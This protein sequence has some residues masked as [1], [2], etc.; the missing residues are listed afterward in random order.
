[1]IFSHD[2]IR[3]P[4][5]AIAPAQ[6]FNDQ[7]SDPLKL[8]RPGSVH[9]REQADLL[10]ALEP[11]M[12]EWGAARD[13]GESDS[14]DSPPEVLGLLAGLAPGRRGRRRGPRG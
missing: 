3:L 6:A 10:S 4:A 14:D 12:R 5:S 11:A 8:P 1:M 13:R 9:R 2:D 7:Q